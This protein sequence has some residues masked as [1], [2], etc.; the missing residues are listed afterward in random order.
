M[1][2]RL[3][4][5]AILLF[6][7][8]ILFSGCIKVTTKVNV[9]KDGSGTIEEQVMMSDVVISMM[10]EFMSSFQD[11]T[12]A[13]EVFKLFKEDELKEKASDFGEGVM[14]VS[15]EEI[16]TDGWEGYKAVYSFDDI[17]SIRMEPDPNKAIENGDEEDASE[18]NEEY[19]SFHFTPGDVA[20]LIISRPD[21][22]TNSEDEEENVELD[23]LNQT[24]N[25]NIINMMNGMKIEI[26]LL[27]NGNIV[28]TN[29]TY[30][31]K[32]T[33]TLLKIDFDELLKNKENLEQFKKNPPDNLDEM[34]EIVGN[35]PGM[36]IELQKPVIIKFE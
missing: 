3:I 6:I 17:N 7:P 22:K 13:T 16:K 15:G 35:I 8:G 26:E 28:E 33:I 14:Y 32:S 31:D 36:K 2:M 30:V 27:F 11:S 19:F 34:M 4:K 21:L 18:N 24:L 9:N 20:E 23:T 25:D 10:N 1:E 5:L 12:S 29:A